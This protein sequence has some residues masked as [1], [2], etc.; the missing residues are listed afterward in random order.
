MKEKDTTS[1]PS[2]QVVEML[3]KWDLPVEH[4][5][6][7][8]NKLGE[9]TKASVDVHPHLILIYHSL[10]EFKKSKEKNFQRYYLQILLC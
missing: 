7:F 9:L 8:Y 6:G 1:T 3:K 5:L 2:P 4:Y 10:H